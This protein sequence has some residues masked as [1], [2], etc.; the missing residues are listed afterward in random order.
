LRAV[1]EGVCEGSE[2]GHL[3]GRERVRLAALR[4]GSGNVLARQF[5]VPREPG[6]GLHGILKNLLADRTAPCCVMR[7]EVRTRAATSRVHYAA[8]LGGFGQFGRVPGDL[9]RWHRR[10][11]GPRKLAAKFLGIERLNDAEYAL[12]VLIRSVSCALSPDAAEVVEVCSGRRRQSMRLLTGLAMNFPLK[13]LPVNPCVRAEDEAFSVHLLPLEGKL[14]ALLLALSPRRL[15]R[16][17]WRVK[18]EKGELIEIRLLDR[19]CAEFFLDED[20]VTV[21]RHLTLQV[22]GTLAFVPGAEYGWPA[23]RGAV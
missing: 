1:I 9:A 11:S 20:P 7:C 8:T 18:V 6:A 4:M 13:A 19:D 21:H 22:A 16:R 17:A 14:S 3:P 15:V 10:L 12:A 5:G 23:G 2:V